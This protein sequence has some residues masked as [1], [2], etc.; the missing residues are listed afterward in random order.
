M[1]DNRRVR[2]DPPYELKGPAHKSYARRPGPFGPGGTV[3]ALVELSFLRAVLGR[4]DDAIA[5]AR[6]A[7][8]RS[9]T[10]RGALTQLATMYA[11]AGDEDGL[12]RLIELVE[13]ARVDR[14]VLLYCQTRLAYVRGDFNDAVQLGEALAALD[15]ADVKVHNLLGSAY[16]ALS[17][18]DRA[19][20]ALEASLQITPTDP[21]VL[22]NLGTVALRSNDP[23]LASERFS[24]ALFLSPT[25]SGA[26]EGLA[27]AY[28]RQ[29]NRA[30]AAEV[31]ARISAH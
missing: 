13:Q 3:P 2:K 4:V 9:P 16:A 10:D 19:R 30:R 22:V 26:L 23:V 1:D 14:G 18:Y 11:D 17:Q 6:D 7:V 25:H 21:G 20:Q 29:G 15:P 5:A 27:E 28:D 12:L 24:E 8:V 31:R